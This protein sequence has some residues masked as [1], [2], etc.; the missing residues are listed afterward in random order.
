MSTEKMDL[1]PFCMKAR[2]FLKEGRM[3]DALG[4]YADVLRIDPDHA[5][6]YADRGT[7]HAMQ[8]QFDLA[9]ADLDRA[10]ALG[11][12]QSAAYSTAG[13]I[14]LETRDYERALA[15]YAR[16]IELDPAYPYT[17]YNRANVY[18]GLGNKE[19]ALADLDTCLGFNPPDD[20]RQLVLKRI[21]EV[22]QS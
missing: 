3:D 14:C 11:H 20:F 12:A 6:A 2:A 17:Y 22:G 16:A 8:K 18:Q 15:Y 19:A 21:A 9:L 5:L 7:V 1:N 10:F 4:L 13:T